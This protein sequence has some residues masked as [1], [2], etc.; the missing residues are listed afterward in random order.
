MGVTSHSCTANMLR[1]GALIIFIFFLTR[2]KV[3][4]QATTTTTTTESVTTSPVVP[5][6]CTWS[7]NTLGT[8]GC[9][10]QLFVDNTCMKAFY[11]T[12]VPPDVTD[13]GEYEGCAVECQENE[14]LIADP[15]DGGSFK[16]LTKLG[17]MPMLCPGAFNTDCTYARRCNSSAENGYEEFNCYDGQI[18]HVNLINFRITCGENDGRCPGAFHV[19]CDQPTTTTTTPPTTSS[20]SDSSSTTSTSST[21]D[22]SS[23]TTS[24][25]GTTSSKAP[26]AGGNITNLLL[27]V[28][29]CLRI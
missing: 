12:E 14:I 27:G 21:S 24:T 26:T 19:G 6:N 4:A 22:S 7:K 2:M 29:L 8:C 15:I 18:V 10:P 23:T 20:T 16:G 3:L 9:S 11:C 13:G 25:A 28:L 17:P 1:S 5:E